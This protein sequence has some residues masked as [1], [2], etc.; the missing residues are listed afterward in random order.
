MLKRRYLCRVLCLLLCA[1]FTAMP[2]GA[3]VIHARSGHAADLQAAINSASTG[4]T[5]SIPSG[6]FSFTGTVYAP[7]G[8]YIRGAGRD[9]TFLVKSDNTSV[10]MIIVDAKTGLPFKF[11]DITVQGRLDALQKGNRTTAVTTVADGGLY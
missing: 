9:S 6:R 11:S 8:I 2:A 1:A 5:I 4:D 3:A 7:D 10:P